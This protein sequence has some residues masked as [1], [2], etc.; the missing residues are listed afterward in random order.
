MSYHYSAL[1]NSFVDSVVVD[2]A[3]AVGGHHR[4]VVNVDGN[5][6]G[7]K[8]GY[9]VHYLHFMKTYKGMHEPPQ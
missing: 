8:Q 1:G 2:T 4:I 6:K 5:L 3:M 9:L 7:K